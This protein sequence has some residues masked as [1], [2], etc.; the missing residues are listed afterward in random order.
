MTKPSR[1]RR[2]TSFCF[3][4]ALF[5]LAAMAQPTRAQWPLW[6]GDWYPAVE[7]EL[8]WDDNINR[9][10]DG[11][12]EKQDV[13]ITPQLSLQTVQPLG[14]AW[15][16]NMKAYMEGAIHGQYRRLNYLA[17]GAIARVS[18]PLGLD[19]QRAL[20]LAQVGLRYEF[21]EQDFRFGAEVNPRVGVQYRFGE[22]VYSSLYYEYDNRFA[23]E[24][25]IYDRTGHTFGLDLDVELAP[26]YGLEAGY[27]YRHGDVLVHEPTDT[28]A[29]NVPNRVFPV[30]NTFKSRYA[31]LKF[32]DEET[33]RFYIGGYY[34]INLYTSVNLR[35][36]Y[37]D[38]RANNDSYPSQQIL[39]TVTHLL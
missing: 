28:P 6:L 5:V 37:E 24:N 7:I 10:I 23:S 11:D 33:H 29:P 39:L 30:D 19:D 36:A 31:A 13:V 14:D 35:L 34:A 38:I 21:H 2:L 16:A 22:R 27:S 8:K 25:E 17:P 26:E 15:S 4:A 9:S 1:H 18:R 12:G 3:V 32:E 20:V